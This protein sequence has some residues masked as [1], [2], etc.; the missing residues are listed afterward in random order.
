MANRSTPNA[1]AF[2]KH[3]HKHCI[4][5]ALAK[6]DRYCQEHKLRFTPV[7]RGT[8]GILLENHCAMGAY[9]VLQRL[10]EKGLGSKPPVAY[11]ALGFLV[12]I[13]FAHRVEKLNAFIACSHPG[14]SHA[15]AFLIC[16]DCG[17]VAESPVNKN[18]GKLAQ[19][20]RLSGFQIEHTI[21]EAE[22][23]CPRCQ[24]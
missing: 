16:S 23:Q 24:S 18:S 21:M 17:A 2:T 13:G 19:T 20:A 10:N 1:M 6:A 4:T 14:S 12:D 22:G 8:L 11:R 9:E 5:Q 15:P 3:D 7:R